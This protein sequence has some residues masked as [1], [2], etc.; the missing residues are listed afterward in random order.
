MSKKYDTSEWFKNHVATIK[1]YGE[2]KEEI[3]IIDW[4]EPKSCHFYVNYI[5]F[6]NRLYVYGDIGEA[7]Y[8]WSSEIGL[9]F[10]KRISLDYFASKCEAS[11]T[12]RDYED[13]DQDKAYES[14]IDILKE[15]YEDE[16]CVDIKNLS[17]K[18]TEEILNQWIEEK[19]EFLTFDELRD[20]CYTKD[21]W[22]NF[23]SEH[24]EFF[25]CDFYEYSGGT[26]I[27][28]RCDGHLT[29][30][31]MAIQ[32]IEEREKNVECKND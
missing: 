12:G 23:L 21:G 2:G 9:N 32:Q 4:R 25:G 29:G 16:K 22:Y 20:A 24:Q 8:C 3:I 10:L 28:I 31:K 5:I 18:E 15:Q 6:K 26:I 14:A 13:W 17:E 30:L 19:D 27:H 11:E 7:V 1:K